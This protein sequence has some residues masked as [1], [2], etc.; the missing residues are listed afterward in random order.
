M[1][2]EKRKEMERILEGMSE[3][4]LPTGIDIFAKEVE[5]VAR[6]EPGIALSLAEMVE[7]ALNKVGE[8]ERN[9][10]F[11]AIGSLMALSAHAGAGAMEH[12][13]P[14]FKGAI[15]AMSRKPPKWR[16]EGL[17]FAR[18]YVTETPRYKKASL[19]RKIETAIKPPV[20]RP[21]ILAAIDQWVKKDLL[22]PP[23]K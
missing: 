23:L 21:T 17:E 11:A 9:R 1:S 18:R 15:G 16:A 19:A 13:L 4:D 22:A 10:V 14:R 12:A 8:P 20:D 3:D 7:A 5:I 2:D 6:H